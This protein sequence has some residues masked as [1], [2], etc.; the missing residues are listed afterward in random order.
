MPSDNLTWK[1]K[2]DAAKEKPL[3]REID[4]AVYDL[5]SKSFYVETP[6]RNW[7]PV[8]E[9]MFKRM[10]LS[11]GYT[12]QDTKGWKMNPADTMLLDIALKQNVDYAG[13]LAGYAAGTRLEVNGM[14]ILVS[15]S[16][17]L[18]APAKGKCETVERFFGDLLD[19]DGSQL[20]RFLGWLKTSLAALRA[21]RYRPAPVLVLAG[22]AQCGKTKAA[23]LLTELLG[24]RMANPYSFMMGGTDFNSELFGAEHLIV[25]DEIPSTDIR[26]R[27]AFGS[28]VKQALYSEGARFHPKGGKAATLRPFW[29]LTVC[30]NEEPEDLM[31]LPPMGG[32]EAMGEKFLVL[33]CRRPEWLPND[34]GEW[35]RLWVAL[36]GELPAFVALLDK[37]KVPLAMRDARSGVRGWQHPDLAEAL[38]ELSPEMML[39][40][41]IDRC[42]IAGDSYWEGTASELE[43]L[44]RSKLESWE[45]DR[46]FKFSNSCGVYLGRL[47]A[48]KKEQITKRKTDGVWRWKIQK[49]GGGDF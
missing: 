45:V 1:Q 39:W 15:N 28:A 25:D 14:K 34:A 24:G 19:A 17:R 46:V 38:S 18:I 43:H 36:V 7:I 49:R 30:L 3:A 4:W 29:R 16:P 20:P 23:A 2:V 37:F 48:S 10:L 9:S 44:L 5:M 11:R 40:A 33:K 32:D 26:S 31:V 6:A 27:R 21:G 13:P 22:P 35:A 8:K 41:M 47:A 12:N 42:K